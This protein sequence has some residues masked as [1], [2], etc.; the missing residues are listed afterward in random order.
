MEPDASPA[1][2][3]EPLGRT[4]AVA[5]GLAA[6]GG[7]AIGLAVA[8]RVLLRADVRYVQWASK[9]IAIAGVGNAL[10]AAAVSVPCALF[11]SAL[12][13]RPQHRSAP[14]SACAALGAI[15][16]V[17][18]FVGLG[19]GSFA[20]TVA[21]A[22]AATS[23]LLALRELLAWWPFPARASTWWGLLGLATS[24]CVA[25]VAEQ[26]A[27]GVP[28]F[29]AFALAAANA[30]VAG[31]AFLGRHAPHAATLGLLA[32]I[33][34]AAS[35]HPE[36]RKPETA[37][38]AAHDVLLITVDTLR[39]DHLGCYGSAGAR[40]PAIDGLAAEGVLFEDAT[41]QANTTG[42][43]HTTILT[44]LYP[45]EH[46]ALSNSVP[47]SNGARTLADALRRT[48]STAAFV[49]GF[50]LVDELCGL[51]P[52]FDW[53]D[54]Q[55]TPLPWLPRVA[56]RLRLVGAAI[57]AAADFGISY[58]GYDR[59][60]GRTAD[61]ALEWLATR[62]DEPLF[63]WLHLFDPHAP[64]EPPREHAALHGVEPGRIGQ[65][66]ELSTREREA[67][68]SDPAAIERMRKLYAAEITYADEQVGRVLDALRASGRYERTLIVLAADH[69]ESLGAHGIWFDHGGHL[70]EDE[71]RV[72]LILRF[73]GGGHAGTRVARQVRLLDVAPTVLEVLGLAGTMPASGASLVEL[74][75]GRADERER[76]SYAISDISGNL[77]GFDIEGRRLSLRTRG[78]KLIW[79]SPHW[80]DTLAVGA[81][82]QYFDL[83]RDPGETDDLR[84]GDRVP[85]APFEDLQK[86]L[87]A[88][89]DATATLTPEREVDDAVLQ[90]LRKLGYL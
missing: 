50:T 6:L 70:Y 76:A 2:P 14:P 8:A 71:L 46:G 86:Q 85:S 77:S 55:L 25:L 39:A 49:S 73:P 34:L 1:P 57:R 20:A 72:P 7:A 30:G 29:L 32:L 26:F 47:L 40:T 74:A 13:G 89:R 79:S 64:Y 27:E 36:R 15:A 21:A 42:P 37:T 9:L 33:L 43:S 59:P 51:A 19:I 22:L 48:H 24:A 35:S 90:E 61:A 11:A 88:W 44:G 65:W 18:A 38:A 17:L 63:T 54:D 66:Y 67:L 87:H 56:E 31:R 84:A 68:V 16:A 3:R 62:G 10:L 69:G 41:T 52:R 45:A 5:A 80:L 83:G 60:A 81:A 82:E 4:L 12:A 28:R 75:S 23:V 53:Y 58:R 78:H